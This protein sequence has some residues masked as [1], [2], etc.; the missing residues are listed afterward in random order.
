MKIIVIGG[1]NVGYYLSRSLLRSHQHEIRLIEKEKDKC[2]Y[3]ADRLDISVI[4]G[5][6]TLIRTLKKAKAKDADILVAITG[7]DQDNFVAAQLAK[8]YFQIKNVIVKANNPKNID[9]L[10]TLAA[11]IVVS[12]INIITGLIEQEVDAVGMRFITRMHMGDSSILEFIVKDNDNLV[13]KS[14]SEIEFPSN[15]LI[16]TI[17]RLGKTIIPTGDTVLMQ[18]DDVMIATHEKNKKQLAKLFQKE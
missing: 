1:G 11:D 13:G 8:H 5:D 2:M 12:S 7:N 10:K 4:H 3:V 6:G 15:T 17:Q 16:V 18:G 9:V 14:L